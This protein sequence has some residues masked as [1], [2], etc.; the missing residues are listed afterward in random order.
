VAEAV[1]AEPL[2]ALDV[3]KEV[4]QELEQRIAEVEQ[5]LTE[6]ERQIV[7]HALDLDHLPHDLMNEVARVVLMMDAPSAATYLREAGCLDRAR[8]LVEAAGGAS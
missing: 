4:I 2:A 8:R 5:H 6:P 1:A 7:H 3:P